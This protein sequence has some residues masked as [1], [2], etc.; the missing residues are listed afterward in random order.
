[1]NSVMIM[2][3]GTGSVLGH[4]RKNAFV[5]VNNLE[6]LLEQKPNF[7]KDFFTTGF[8]VCTKFKLGSLKDDSDGED[9]ERP[10]VLSSFEQLPLDSAEELTKVEP[11]NFKT[12]ESYESDSWSIYVM[13]RDYRPGNTLWFRLVLNTDMHVALYLE[14]QEI[15]VG[16]NAVL[17]DYANAT[18]YVY[19]V[20]SDR[21]VHVID[22]RDARILL[23]RT[24]Y[25]SK[26]SH[27]GGQLIG[28]I[29]EKDDKN[30][31]SAQALTMQAMYPR[32]EYN[33]YH[34]LASP[35]LFLQL[36]YGKT[37]QQLKD[38]AASEE[39]SNRSVVENVP[40]D[41]SSSHS[42][43]DRSESDSSWDVV[44]V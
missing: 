20:H 23:K 24:L 41:S 42:A 18:F 8:S 32:A 4:D 3:A 29:L 44:F 30:K 10:A 22:A 12:L 1:M 13:D 11:Y 2:T 31:R 35:D 19:Y 28:E 39:A 15:L 36:H 17:E 25:R 9:E 5:P 37:L 34:N 38:E 26:L 40:P 33:D 14:G 27:C 7:L 21:F 43:T 6:G 16:V